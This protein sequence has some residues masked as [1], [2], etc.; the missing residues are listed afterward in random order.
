[1]EI[2]A[3]LT[4]QATGAP[5]TETVRAHH[6]FGERVGEGRAM[7]LAGA[8]WSYVHE[9]W[10][11]D[12]VSA[13]ARALFSRRIRGDLRDFLSERWNSP[14]AALT[15]ELGLPLSAF[16]ADWQRQLRERAKD[17]RHAERLARDPRASIDVR[18]QPATDFDPVVLV[19]NFTAPLNPQATC[20]ALH[21]VERWF[22]SWPSPEQ[23]QSETVTIASDRRGFRH[24]LDGDYESGERAFVA[25]D[26]RVPGL[27]GRTRLVATR[28]TIP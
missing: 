9:R 23:L 1:S 24:T 28:V 13:L 15:R 2:E 26:C 25:V 5:T 3:L 6:S 18:A 21:M 10:G 16:V 14:E 8:A 11:A 20:Q 27:P 17:P 19:G 7:A 12:K 22:D 4:A